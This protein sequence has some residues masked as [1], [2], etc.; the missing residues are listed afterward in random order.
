ML[1]YVLYYTKYHRNTVR[2]Y[3]H[4]AMKGN[5]YTV[6][7]KGSKRTM[8]RFVTGKPVLASVLLSLLGTAL[9]PIGPFIFKAPVAAAGS[10]AA[11]DWI[12]GLIGL[13]VFTGIFLLLYKKWFSPEFSGMLN[14]NLSEGFFLLLPFV[15]YWAINLA[16]TFIFKRNTLAF[17][18]SGSIIE[19]SIIAGVM[20]EFCF[21]GLIIATLLRQWRKKDKFLQAAI[22]SGIAFGLI[23]ALNAAAGANPLRTLFQVFDAGFLGVFLAANYMR[24]GSL[25]PVMIAHALHDIMAIGMASDVAENGIIT[26]G[27]SFDNI[28]DFIL[29]LGLCVA[30]IYMLRSDKIKEIRQVWDKKWTN[31]EHEEPSLRA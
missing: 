1:Y 10:L 4:S 18:M 9:I 22:I 6:E 3:K 25:L 20:E 15:A 29:S 19:T 24:C 21:R 2:N 26:G 12:F 5:L 7:N 14:G 16:Y 8:H 17:H 13:F 11:L 31:V 30:G 23:H 27:I 28:V